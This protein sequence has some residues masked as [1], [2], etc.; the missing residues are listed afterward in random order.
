MESAKSKKLERKDLVLLIMAIVSSFAILSTPKIPNYEEALI[1]TDGS[2]NSL[3][4]FIAKMRIYIDVNPMLGLCVFLLIFLFYKKYYC[5]IHKDNYITYMLSVIYAAIML[6]GMSIQRFGD[7]S[8]IFKNQFQVVV[9]IIIFVGYVYFFNQ[10]ICGIFI[11]LDR[12]CNECEKE[13]TDGY[14]VFIKSFIILI[15]CW[16][17]YWIAFFPG[18]VM[19][20]PFVQFNYYFGVFEWSD[21][22]PV[23]S[24]LIYG[25]LMAIGRAVQNDNMGIFLCVLYQNILLASS[26]SYGIYVLNRW[27]VNKKI[28]YYVILFFSLMPIIAFQAQSVMK[29]VSYYAVIIAFGVTYLDILMDL[30]RK[31]LVSWRKFILLGVTAILA[32]LLRHNGIY[33]CILPMVVLLVKKKQR[34][35]GM[36]IA[37]TSIV[38]LLMTSVISDTLIRITDATP[39]SQGEMMSIPFQQIAR[40]VK[41]HGDE[42]TE[43]EKQV[44]NG[45]LEYDVLSESYNPDIS[46]PVKS[47][48]RGT[49][50]NKEFW[51][52]WVKY[53]LKYPKVYFE[54]FF[55][56]TYSYF[57]PNGESTI[58][59]IVYDFICKDNVN[60]G[61]FN[62]HYVNE[63]TEIRKMFDN[64]LY[65]LNSFPGIGIIF[66]QGFY[67]WMILLYCSYVICKKISY[68][69]MASVPLLL[70]LLICFASPVNGYF[71]YYMPI[72]FLIPF[73][74][75]WG[76][77]QL[78]N[79]KNGDK[80]ESE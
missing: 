53:F 67:T 9:S 19:W 79:V 52:L 18:S 33:C 55:C 49:K 23:F 21:W 20:D 69:L 50:I 8:F 56:N 48:Y 24:T 58:K 34:K 47:I 76:W 1:L 65:L 77:S 40:Y 35:V 63:N 70:H 5:L 73:L 31:D 17:P 38:I 61:Y 14:K 44:I 74:Y 13:L 62:I 45:V 22:H 59:P 36:Q 46:D 12:K 66:H 10:V 30:S 42:L 75:V 54:A 64:L 57:Y 25:I 68:G 26:I 2:M 72:I 15:L 16:L 32:G 29:D 28:R 11:W 4:T 51:N 41:Y 3:L 80:L 71:R 60:T 6:I 7:L 43:E 39:K 78:L 27:G 37:I